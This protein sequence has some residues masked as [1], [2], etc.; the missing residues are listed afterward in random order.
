MGKQIFILFLLTLSILIGQFGFIHSSSADES[1]VG[2]IRY[3]IFQKHSLGGSMAQSGKFC[4]DNP[5]R[6]TPN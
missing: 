2:D 1:H 6:M 4:E 5:C 3:S